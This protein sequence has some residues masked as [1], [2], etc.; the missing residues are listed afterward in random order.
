M[1]GGTNDP[2]IHAE[3]PAALNEIWR[4]AKA[5]R[6]GIAVIREDDDSGLL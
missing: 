1:I 6:K 4:A 3:V 5:Y 2:A